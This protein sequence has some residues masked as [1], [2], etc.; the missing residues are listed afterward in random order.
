MAITLSDLADRYRVGHGRDFELKDFD[1][2]DTWKLKK[3]QAQ[4]LLAHSS[5]QLSEQQGKLYAQGNWS[6]LLIFQAIDAAGK[7]STIKHVF[8]GVN[9]QGCQVY[10]FKAPS[11]EDLS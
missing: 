1:P 5:E 2:G 4:E 9:P 6:L 11:N 3:E 10:S 8:S 7:D